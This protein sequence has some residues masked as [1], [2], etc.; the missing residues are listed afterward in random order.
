MTSSVAYL[1]ACWH[2]LLAWRAKCILAYRHSK[3]IR[4]KINTFTYFPFTYRTRVLCETK[5]YFWLFGCVTNAGCF[6]T[7]EPR[8]ARSLVSHGIFCACQ[9]GS[10]S[11][12]NSPIIFITWLLA[13][14]LLKWVLPHFLYSWAS[15][16]KIK[17]YIASLYPFRWSIDWHKD[18]Q[19]FYIGTYFLLM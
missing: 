16:L 14:F 6:G 3:Q 12:M 11:P 15:M 13:T 5:F 17:A 2:H 1:A 18:E 4:E 10:V 9:H 7:A 19:T 8:N